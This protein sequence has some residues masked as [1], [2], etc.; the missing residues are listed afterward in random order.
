METNT[1]LPKSIE[2]PIKHGDDHK[3]GRRFSRIAAPFVTLLAIV[4]F[5]LGAIAQTTTSNVEGTVKDANGAVIAGAQVK[6]TG[7]TVGT[8]RTAVTNQDGFYR[9]A[10]VPAG[11]YSVSITQ[12]GFSVSRSNFEVTLNRT[13]TA[14]FQLQ[15]GD[16]GGTE[17]TV[18]S[19]P[20]LIDPTT[21]ATGA[22]I[23]PKQIQDLPVNGREYLDL[24]QLVPGVAI[25]RQSSATTPIRCSA[26]EA[27]TT[28]SL[29]TDSR[30]RTPSQAARRHRSIRKPLRNFRY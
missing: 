8:E 23:M 11:N 27:A 10:S 15:V 19:D 16:V 30:T 17:V 24:L 28:I 1:T 6:L 9:F 29:S 3:L 14:D 12:T 26:N 20:P 13:V 21:T 7:E 25:N 2:T 22:T 5:S 4:L 18:T